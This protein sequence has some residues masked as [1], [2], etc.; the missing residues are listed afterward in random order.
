MTENDSR[1][2]ELARQVTPGASQTWSKAPGRVGPRDMSG[3]FPLF[4]DSGVGPYLVSDG[5]KFLDMFGAN[6][7]IPLGYGRPEVVRAVSAAVTSGS[8]LSLPSPLEEQVSRRFLATCAP[9]AAQVRWTRTGSEALQAAVRIARAKTRRG[10]VLV[11]DSAYHGWHDWFQAS[12]QELPDGRRTTAQAMYGGPLAPCDVWK[13]GTLTLYS[14]GTGVFEYGS[15]RSLERAAPAAGMSTTAGGMSPLVAAVVIEPHRWIKTDPS[16][17]FAVKRWC[18]QHGAVLIFDELVYGLRWRI[19]GGAEF[20]GVEPDLACFGK[21]LGNGVPVACVC[22][23]EPIMRYT[24]DAGISGTYGGDTIGLSAA[25]AVLSV[26]ERESVIA[27]LWK[28][29]EQTWRGFADGVRYSVA[30]LEGF[31]VHWRLSM[32]SEDLMDRTLALAADRLVLVSRASNN[33]S[34]AMS[35]EEAYHGGRVLGESARKALEETDRV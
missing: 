13:N 20:Y 4:A 8:L 10:V 21:A 23:T 32:P 35:T 14:A 26:Y 22:G 2:L 7:A 3:G 15:M 24:I 6:A 19:G 25:A 1:R 18:I 17:L 33:A 5:R 11:A 34:A 16:F 9:W 29:G 27:R 30:R 28:N 31:P 12:T